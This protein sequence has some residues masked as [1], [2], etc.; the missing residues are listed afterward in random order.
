M[1][2]VPKVLPLNVGRVIVIEYFV[3]DVVIAKIC[4]P[5]VQKGDGEPPVPK[6]C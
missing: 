4:P 6:Y 2:S 5:L 3:Q 1:P